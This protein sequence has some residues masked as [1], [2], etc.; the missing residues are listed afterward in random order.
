[1]NQKVTALKCLTISF[2]KFDG[3]L[4][5][6]HLHRMG[7]P[8]NPR[9]LDENEEFIEEEQLIKLLSKQIGIDIFKISINYTDDQSSTISLY[10]ASKEK[11]DTLFDELKTAYQNGSNSFTLSFPELDTIVNLI[12]LNTPRRPVHIHEEHE[13]HEWAT[14]DEGEIDLFAWSSETH[15]GPRCVRCGATPCIYCNHDFGKERCVADKYY[16]PHCGAEVT[17]YSSP[18]GCKKCRQA[19]D[20]EKLNKEGDTGHEV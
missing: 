9:F 11:N 3:I 10:F 7:P 14:D 16:C 1:M 4:A 18:N 2:D 19:L 20:W 12:S 13:H 6:C 17:K 5:A 15:N 8:F